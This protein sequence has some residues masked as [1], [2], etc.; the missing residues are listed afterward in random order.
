MDEKDDPL[1]GVPLME[2]WSALR[3]PVTLAQPQPISEGMVARGMAQPQAG[4]VVA[5][6]A[7]KRLEFERDVAEHTLAE[8]LVGAGQKSR[9]VTLPTSDKRR[10]RI[11][12]RFVK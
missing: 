4:D 7:A 1:A 12:L 11:T 3:I 8:W 5:R 9:S 6:V 2:D 10:V